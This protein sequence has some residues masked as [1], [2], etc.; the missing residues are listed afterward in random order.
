VQLAQ[1]LYD[2]GEKTVAEIAAI[3]LAGDLDEHL[4][5]LPLVAWARPAAAQSVGVALPELGAPLPDRLVGII[6]STSR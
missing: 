5:E 1:Q 6:S 3:F 4:V 2:A